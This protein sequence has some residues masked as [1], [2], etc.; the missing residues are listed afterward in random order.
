MGLF[1]LDMNQNTII[2]IEN[3]HLKCRLQN[4]GHYV[5]D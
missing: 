2:F 5:Q 4:D 3:M 1:Q